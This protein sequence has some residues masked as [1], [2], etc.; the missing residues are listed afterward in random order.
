MAQREDGER[1][2]FEILGP[3]RAF[4][5]HRELDLGPH[6]QRAILAVLLVNAN[7]TVSINDLVDAVWVDNPPHNG[8]NVVQKYVAGLRR[9]LE[10]E[11]VARAP[12]QRLQRTDGGYRLRVEAGCL[13]AEQLVE[14]QAE[15]GELA[16]CG[17][18]EATVATLRDALSLWHGEPLAGMAGP[19]FDRAR[20]RLA[21]TR[22]GICETLAELEIAAGRHRQMVAEL[23]RLVA[24]FPL[25]DEP[26]YL[27][28]LALHRSGRQVEALEVYQD[29]R[30]FLADEFGIEP[31]DRLRDL[32]VRILRSDPALDPPAEAEP[33]PPLAP[34]PVA[35]TWRPVAVSAVAS[36][37]AWLLWLG[38]AAMA[39][40]PLLSLGFGGGVL[41]TVV[42]IARRR[43][44]SAIVGGAYVVAIVTGVVVAAAGPEASVLTALGFLIWYGVIGAST[45]HGVLLVPGPER[46]RY[47]P[48]NALLRFAAAL[49]PL[50]TFGFGVWV[51][52]AYHAIRRRSRL[53]SAVA[54]GYAI[55]PAYVLSLLALEID[56]PAPSD[57]WFAAIDLMW[58]SVL[59]A[60][61]H[62]A[63][64]SPDKYRRPRRAS[65]RVADFV[66]LTVEHNPALGR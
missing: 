57:G 66:P 60:V 15:A 43:V 11:R 3:V 42:A 17:A 40:V 23:V 56:R 59:V 54:I 20:D 65:A 41:V 21:E 29:G 44:V 9:A 51:P 8:A 16:S 10:P 52:F 14:L 61:P 19:E 50:L 2:R 25:R 18:A 46:P 27:L 45:I 12:G 58:L 1:L 62:A 6:K 38:K 30:E 35:Q 55:L 32:H 49:V 39:L 13:D 31:S 36:V 26:R 4:A 37:P 64:L 24:D 5:G 34:T 47:G 48:A 7:K 63:F 22:A 53:L 33:A 28:M